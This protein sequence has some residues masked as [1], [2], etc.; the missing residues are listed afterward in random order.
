MP[1]TSLDAWSLGDVCKRK[2]LRAAQDWD[3]PIAKFGWDTSTKESNGKNINKGKHEAGAV[4]FARLNW[5][6]S[7]I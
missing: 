1:F 3:A 2:A 6:T 5:P 7:L 4:E